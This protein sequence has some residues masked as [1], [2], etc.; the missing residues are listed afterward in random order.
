MGEPAGGGGGGGGGGGSSSRLPAA[1]SSQL[2][3]YDSSAEVEGGAKKRGRPP[4]AQ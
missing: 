3:G 4:K 1:A 2:S